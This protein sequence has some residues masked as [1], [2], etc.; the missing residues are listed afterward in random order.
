VDTLRALVR[1]DKKHSSLYRVFLEVRDATAQIL[2]HTSLADLCSSGDV[3]DESGAK[4]KASGARS[5]KPEARS[6]K[7]Q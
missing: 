1:L 6:Q 3:K 5:P 7:S 2:D 4:G